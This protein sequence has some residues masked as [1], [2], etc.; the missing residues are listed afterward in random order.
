MRAARDAG[1]WFQAAGCPW[2]AV[3]ARI[4]SAR[5]CP[6]PRWTERVSGGCRPRK[7]PEEPGGG[8]AGWGGEVRP[9][10]CAAWRS[11]PTSLDSVLSTAPRADDAWI[12]ALDPCLGPAW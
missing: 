3:A 1:V 5:C 6:E 7:R 12:R 2:A 11:S 8:N 10:G 9:A 4:V